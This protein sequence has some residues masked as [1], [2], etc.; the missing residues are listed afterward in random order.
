M[1]EFMDGKVVEVTPA[2]IVLLVNGI[3][4]L[5]YTA[6][7]Y[8]FEVDQDRTVRV[9]IYQAVSDSAML[10]YGFY[11]SADKKLFEKLIN[12]S[13]IGPKSALA[14]LAG[15]DRGGLI[16]AINNK[17]VKFLTR[18]PGVGKKTA[19]QIILD[20]QGKMA[21]LIQNA[22]VETETQSDEGQSVE[23]KDALSALKALG[24]PAK[25]V[26][27]I[28]PELAKKDGL[29]TDEYLSLGLKLLMH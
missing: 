18:F 16:S 7:P 21:D 15:K 9:Y 22:A 14:I 4:Y 23:L 28:A 17:D 2:Y 20:L 6:D 25:Q 13:G 5:I 27:A 12:V 26:M 24:Y 1:Y 11:E 3:G 29:T 8:R 19:Q 10:L